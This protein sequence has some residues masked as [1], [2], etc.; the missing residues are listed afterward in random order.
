VKKI[1]IIQ[2]AFLGDV[3]LATPL[4]SELNRIFPTAQLDLLVRKGNESLLKNNPNIQQVFTFNKKE[5]KLKSLMRII[6]SIRKEKYDTVINLQR[7]TTSG[8]ITLCSGATAKIGF[9]KNPLAFGYTKKIKHT[10]EIGKHEIERNLACIEHLGG[11]SFVAPKLYPSDADY[12]FIQSLKTESFVCL[13][14]AS[15]WF[16]KQLPVEK[17]IELGR[18]KSEH[19]IVYL[20]GGPADFELCEEIRLKIG[21]DRVHNLAGTLSLLQ[22]AALMKNAKRTY[23][24]DSGPMHLASAMNAPVTA[25]YCSTLPSFGFG[26]VSDD[27]KIAEIDFQLNCRP[28]GLHGH[29]ACPQGH[30]K[31]GNIAISEL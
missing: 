12:E 19:E 29:K 20:I 3:V 17:W 22:S 16:T 11:K 5:G 23:T 18:R 27:S 31:C 6:R 13:A 8:L 30:F 4:I 10:L 25:F 7:F 24:N 15:I 9:D 28:C 1:L 21:N 26:P 2:T 14:P